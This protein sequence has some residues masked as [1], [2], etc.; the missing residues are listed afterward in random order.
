MRWHW[1]RRCQLETELLPKE[2]FSAVTQPS[3]VFEH[4]T[5]HYRN[6]PFMIVIIMRPLHPCSYSSWRNMAVCC[7]LRGENSCSRWS[8]LHISARHQRTT[9]TRLSHSTVMIM[10]VNPWGESEDD[11]NNGLLV[12]SCTGTYLIC[13]GSI[14]LKIY[15]KLILRLYRKPKQLCLSC[16]CYVIQ[17]ILL[18]SSVQSLLW[19]NNKSMTNVGSSWVCFTWHKH[20]IM[21]NVLLFFS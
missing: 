2:V 18:C 8:I 17:H 19:P 9:F 5:D 16:Y 12:L 3:M 10:S 20:F 4:I 7:S 14:G 11:G 6:S 15:V 1:H 13:S 21:I